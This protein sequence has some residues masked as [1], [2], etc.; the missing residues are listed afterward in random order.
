MF[1]DLRSP[2]NFA[3][4]YIAFQG[5]ST[6]QFDYRYLAGNMIAIRSAV[7]GQKSR[8]TPGEIYSTLRRARFC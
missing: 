2:L 7:D 5:I 1:P 8:S 3:H 6:D 4:A